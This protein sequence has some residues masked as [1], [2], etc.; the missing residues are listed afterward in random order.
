MNTRP[1]IDES[2]G[3]AV[4]SAAF[5][6]NNTCFSVALENGFRGIGP[7]GH[8]SVMLTSTPVYSA[9]SCDMKVARGALRSPPQLSFI[10]PLLKLFLDRSRDRYRVRRDARDDEVPRASWRGEAA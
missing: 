2:S 7:A 10:Y 8:K 3:P 1:A 5:N 4:L 9:Q 6:T